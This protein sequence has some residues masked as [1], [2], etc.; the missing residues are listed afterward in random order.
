M[1]NLTSHKILTVAVALLALLV[2][3]SGCDKKN[4]PAAQKGPAGLV[5]VGVVV[6]EPQRLPMTVKLSGRISSH[7]VAEVRPQVGGIIKERLFTEGSEVHAGQVLYQIDP[8]T[9][10]AA[11]AGAKA[12]LARS[13][14]HLIQAQLK[15][16]RLRDLSGAAAVSR[17]DYDDAYAV[18]KQAE[19]DIEAAKAALEAAGINLAYTRIVAPITGRIGRSSVTTGALVTAG[20][21]APLATIQQLDTVY[22]DVSQ[23]SIEMLAMKRA[24][25]AGQLQLSNAGEA[26]VNLILED[27]SPYPHAG[28][29]KFSEVSV[30]QGTGSV[31]LRTVFTNPEQLLLPGMFVN[32]VLETGIKEQAILVPQQG[33]S[34][35]PAGRAIGLVVGEGDKAEVRVLKVEQAIGDKWLVTGGLKKGDQLIVEGAQK[36]RPGQPVKAAVLEATPGAL[37]PQAAP[38]KM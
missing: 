35:D 5:E 6:V 25:T 37:T 24:I 12:G 8:A 27:G 20:Q 33:V 4:N 36:V 23:P 30:D 28:V 1:Y 11:V 32:A 31:T 7:L 17:Q 3:Q 13:E 29:L 10:Q 2:M 9:Y 38:T 22:V 26:R 19:A 21:Q 18:L 14:A 16:K 15:E 34:H